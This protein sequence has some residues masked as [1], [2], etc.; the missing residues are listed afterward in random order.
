MAERGFKAAAPRVLLYAVIGFFAML[1]AMPLYVMLVNSLKPLDEIR[2][3]D[4]MAWPQTLTVQPWHDAWSLANIGVQ[5]TGL[6]PYFFNSFLM[7]VPAV[8]ISTMIGALN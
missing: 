2:T 7:V 8:A 4:L 6:R 3:G 5:A 1:F